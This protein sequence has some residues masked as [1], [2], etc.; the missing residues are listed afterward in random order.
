MDRVEIIMLINILQTHLIEMQ[1][2]YDI[3][4]Q[5]LQNNLHVISTC[6]SICTQKIIIGVNFI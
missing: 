6:I 3:L 4:L 5:L 2:E 1:H